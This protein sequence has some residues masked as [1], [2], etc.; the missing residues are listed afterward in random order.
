MSGTVPKSA[1]SNPIMRPPINVI[2]A[3]PACKIHEYSQPG[4]TAWSTMGKESGP[5]SSGLVPRRGAVVSEHAAATATTKRATA[6]VG[7][8]R[9]RKMAFIGHSASRSTRGPTGSSACEAA[10]P[11][12]EKPSDPE[13]D[14]QS[15]TTGKKPDHERCAAPDDGCQRGRQR[16]AEGPPR[17]HEGIPACPPECGHQAEQC[18]ETEGELG[19]GLSQLTWRL[20]LGQLMD[21]LAEAGPGEPEQQERND[22]EE[23]SPDQQADGHWF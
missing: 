17:E 2:G 1:A 21:T 11:Q 5:M 4:L 3:F 10:G 6:R 8:M 13:T 20:R 15:P 18:E 23:R 19:D 9:S 7:P 12:T 16:D 14:Q 22:G